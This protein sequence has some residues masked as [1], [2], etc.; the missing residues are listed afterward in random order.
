MQLKK[1]RSLVTNLP[2]LSTKQMIQPGLKRKSCS[3]ASGRL[4]AFQTFFIKFYS[5]ATSQ[6]FVSVQ[7]DRLVAAGWITWGVTVWPP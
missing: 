1:G 4:E 6:H 5:Q 3:I 7:L 2:P